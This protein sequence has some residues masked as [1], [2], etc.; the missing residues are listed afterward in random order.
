M[1]VF[2]RPRDT[3]LFPAA[4]LGPVMDGYIVESEEQLS[5]VVVATTSVLLAAFAVGFAYAAVGAVL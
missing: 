3:T 2:V 4:V 1:N 5:P